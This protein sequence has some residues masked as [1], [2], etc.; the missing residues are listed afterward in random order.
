MHYA[1]ATGRAK[2]SSGAWPGTR[3]S[4]D[5]NANC[6]VNTQSPTRAPV[7]DGLCHTLTCVCVCVCVC[8]RA[9][10]RVFLPQ[11]DCKEINIYTIQI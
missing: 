10:V 3:R 1:G 6:G 2:Q 8:T 7:A 4:T 11:D 9:C 5:F